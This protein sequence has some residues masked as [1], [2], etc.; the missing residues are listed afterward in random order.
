[1]ANFTA[2]T[3]K[4]FEQLTPPELNMAFPAV[5]QLHQAAMGLLN[6]LTNDH[7]EGPSLRER[8]DAGP[9]TDAGRTIVEL[10]TTKL[11]PKPPG[12][13]SPTRLIDIVA[14]LEEL[15]ERLA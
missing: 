15:D 2:S 14:A 12:P 4:L 3:A 5:K 1:M 7:A 11:P 9:T 6:V 13:P 8:A 10:G